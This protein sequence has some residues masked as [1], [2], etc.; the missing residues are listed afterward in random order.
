MQKLSKLPLLFLCAASLMGLL[1]RWHQYAP[2][3]G[4][5]F[6]YWLH[7]HSH[8][9]FLGW[10]MNALC[11]GY[12]HYFIPGQQQRTYRILIIVL[13]VLV[14]I[15]LVAFP[16]QG[17]AGF[18]IIIS[19]LYTVLA[20]IFGYVFLRDTHSRRK[21]LAIGFARWS[22]IFYFI[23][24]LAP[25]AIGL[26]S[27]TG[28]GQTQAYYLAVYFFLH[29]L[30]NGA[31]TCGI[32]SLL[33]QLLQTKGVELDEKNGQRF[34][35]LLCV[36]CIPA[37]VLSTLWVQPP[38]VY[39]I[40]GFI[41]AILQLIAFYY[42]IC[43]VKVLF[44]KELKRFSWPACALLFVAIACFLLKLVLQLI[45]AF[46]YSAILAYEVRNFVIAY[47]H[48]VLLGMLTFLLLF[49]YQ[50]A[51][52]VSLLAPIRTVVLLLSFILSEV[53]M[54]LIPLVNTAID[55]HLVLVFLSAIIFLS[56]TW[57]F[58]SFSRTSPEVLPNHS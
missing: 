36:S 39:N 37:Y 42:F 6:P 9:M 33:Y 54:L 16:L 3:E 38:L 8:V 22:F 24:S 2:V 25:F 53:V 13:N 23:A 5:I 14:A 50:E 19:T 40:I 31:F 55:L 32:F 58:I 41:A 29:F 43:S 30:Y 17:Y 15:M 34:K 57:F 12:V 26:L 45:S 35:S 11:I 27:A 47:L 4:L 49:W 1:L 44:A 10:I 20:A 28:R 46:P 18:S 21:L 52:Q 7:A 51:F 48:L 56:F